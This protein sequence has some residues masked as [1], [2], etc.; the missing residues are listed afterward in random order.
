MRRNQQ[1]MCWMNNEKWRE[2]VLIL[3][4]TNGGNT[5][6][7]QHANWIARGQRYQ[8][9]RQHRNSGAY[10]EYKWVA[11][12]NC[13][14]VSIQMAEFSWEG[15]AIWHCPWGCRCDCQRTMAIGESCPKGVNMTIQS[16]K[17]IDMSRYRNLG[18]APSG[19]RHIIP[20]IT[21]PPQFVCF[22]SLIDSMAGSTPYK[23]FF[24]A[25]FV[26][27]SQCPH[28]TGNHSHRASPT[29]FI[30]WSQLTLA[31]HCSLLHKRH[32]QAVCCGSWNWCFI[33]CLL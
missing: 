27:S 9:V 6:R 18:I 14:T 25:K 32:W 17:G 1:E 11:R 28:L 13:L 2:T 24:H 10:T 31:I 3:Y 7:Y 19:I 20:S 8:E 26:P 30:L 21:D 23:P 29:T 22:N 16:R 33:L 5:T 12:V 15:K 4:S